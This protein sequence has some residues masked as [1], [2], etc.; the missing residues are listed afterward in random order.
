MAVEI[1][2]LSLEVHLDYCNEL[3]HMPLTHCASK[4]CIAMMFTGFMPFL[5]CRMIY[6]IW[7]FQRACGCIKG[8][9]QDGRPPSESYFVIH[10]YP[11]WDDI[12]EWHKIAD[13]L[14]MIACFGIIHIISVTRKLWITHL[15]TLHGRL[16]MYN[17]YTVKGCYLEPGLL[18]KLFLL[19]VPIPPFPPKHTRFDSF[20]WNLK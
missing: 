1:Q 7:C 3:Y 8:L 20:P 14:V 13:L 17:R 9:H 15:W 10:K 16:L 2:Q 19:Y 4:F 5:C 12:A 6:V 18:W 11:S